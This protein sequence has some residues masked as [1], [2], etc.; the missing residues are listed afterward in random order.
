MISPPQLTN[1]QGS[2]VLLGAVVA[3]YCFGQLVAAPILGFWSDRRSAKEPLIVCFS[4]SIAANLAYCYA[5]ALPIGGEYVVIVA[6]I[7]MG[8]CAGGTD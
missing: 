7:A 3:G 4:V 5:S 8:G 1:G 6:R 2:T